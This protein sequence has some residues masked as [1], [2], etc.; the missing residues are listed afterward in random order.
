MREGAAV[1]VKS[2]S[3]K[4]KDSYRHLLHSLR[5]RY[6]RKQPAPVA[7]RWLSFIK[8]EGDDLDEFAD[9]IR[10]L[11]GDAFP[12][13]E[14]WAEVLREK[15]MADAF[16]RGCKD[17]LASLLAAGNEPETL[18]DALELVYRHVENQKFIGKPFLGIRQVGFEVDDSND[19]E[20]PGPNP[21][22]PHSHNSSIEG[23]VNSVPP[24]TLEQIAQVIEESMRKALVSVVRSKPQNELTDSK[25]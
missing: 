18:D 24:L 16:L 15:I 7:R 4:K 17:K 5:D 11:A 13:D 14:G 23:P 6:D 9:S 10:Q 19:L 12:P 25:T 8:Q 2:L 22:Y 21:S 1:F 3:H 20:S